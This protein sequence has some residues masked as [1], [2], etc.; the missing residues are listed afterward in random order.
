MKPRADVATRGYGSLRKFETYQIVLSNQE[1]LSKPVDLGR[2]LSPALLSC[3]LRRQNESGK[4]A[5][6]E[7]V[8]YSSMS[9]VR[10]DAE[11]YV[12][13]VQWKLCVGK[14]TW[15]KWRLTARAAY[16]LNAAPSFLRRMLREKRCIDLVRRSLSSLAAAAPP[17]PSARDVARRCGGGNLPLAV[18]SLERSAPAT[19]SL[20]ATM[21]MSTT[22]RG[23][24]GRS[25]LT[26][27]DKVIIY[28]FG[29]DRPGLVSALAKAVLDAGGNVEESRMA[30]LGGDFNMMMSVSF[31]SA[32]S[33]A[34]DEGGREGRGERLHVPSTSHHTAHVPSV[35]P[36]A[37]AFV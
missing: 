29:P 26:K 13:G 24:H 22:T 20:T 30:R 3:S 7:R 37:S 35:R 17:Q 19:T 36:R 5:C 11:T 4:K 31:A 2:E 8:W 15:K 28:A 33:L 34:G 16:T 32:E 10:T 14:A 18:R 1:I 12:S 9:T 6:E 21:S 25:P 23:W 27:S